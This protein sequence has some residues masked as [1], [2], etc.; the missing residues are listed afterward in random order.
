MLPKNLTAIAASP[1]RLQ[2]FVTGAVLFALVQ[3]PAAAAPAVVATAHAPPRGEQ[4]SSAPGTG[5]VCAPAGFVRVSE[6]HVPLGSVIRDGE[7]QYCVENKASWTEA[8]ACT[9]FLPAEQY[10][11]HK[12]GRQDA[13]YSGMAVGAEA[14]SNIIL[15]YCLP[16]RKQ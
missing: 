13:V 10:I 2:F 11:R 7:M 1:A 16:P 8:K 14:T 12:T 15:F 3:G 9:K 4:G 6:P 5:Q